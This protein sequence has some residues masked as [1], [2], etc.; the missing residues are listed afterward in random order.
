MRR[1]IMETDFEKAMREILRIGHLTGSRAF[2]T[3]RED[4]DYDIIYNI[5]DAAR[6]NEVLDKYAEGENTP[7]EYF[8]GY[9]VVIGG[10]RVN[11]I[12]L[13][14]ASIVPWKLATVAMAAVKSSSVF[15]NPRV[16]YAIFEGLVS[17]F[18]LAEICNERDAR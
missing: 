3:A 15:E 14:P 5:K 13:S 10:N 18:K 17:A 6:I 1:Q 12:P 11:L 7:S 16:K 4:S 9:T 2:G 8:S